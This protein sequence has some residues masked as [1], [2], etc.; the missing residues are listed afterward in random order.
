MESF[1]NFMVHYRS[2]T[3]RR[4]LVKFEQPYEDVYHVICMLRIPQ[5]MKNYTAI[6]WME[7]RKSDAVNE[8]LQLVYQYCTY[9]FLLL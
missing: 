4:Y 8:L 7:W 1:T 9:F 2:S 6:C 3:L 5:K